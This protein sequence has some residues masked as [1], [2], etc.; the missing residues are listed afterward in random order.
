MAAGV[1]GYLG[2]DM[3]REMERLAPAKPD[4]IGTPD[5]LLVR[6][7]LMAVF[8]PVRDEI[9]LVTPVRP[10]AGVAAK[11]AY[12]AALDRLEAAGRRAGRPAAP[13][14][15][16]AGRAAVATQRRCPTPPKR[17]ISPWSNRPRPISAPATFSRWCC[18]SASP[19][20]SSCR[21]SRSI[22]R[23]AG[24][25]PRPSCAI[26]ISAASRS[27]APARKF[28]CARARAR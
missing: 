26:S 3:V 14:G 20:R 22:A 18:R 6:P 28:W 4:P 25:I 21:P 15:P 19:R 2:Y 7:T 27:S 23:C 17:K 10:Q 12:E 24:S 11:A 1:F 5:A 13:R 8:D 9:S 16:G